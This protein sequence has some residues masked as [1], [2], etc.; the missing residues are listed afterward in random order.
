M[1][2][3]LAVFVASTTSAYA[4]LNAYSHTPT[5]GFNTYNDILCSPNETYV[6]QR[7][8]QLQQLGF[9]AAGYRLFHLD[10]GWSAFNRTSDGS[11]TWD[12]DR[13]PSGILPLSQKA[14]SLGMDWGMYTD[15][16]YYMCDTA[17]FD[18]VKRPGSRDHE[19]QDSTTFK[20]W[21]ASYVKVRT[22]LQRRDVS[23]ATSDSSL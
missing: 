11:L 15:T 22:T 18:N 12:P 13:F 4:K 9:I 2:L 17:G 1:L 20:G 14:A 5:L 23:N 21:N 8:D 19:L 10:C 7:M 16:G 6:N 3:T